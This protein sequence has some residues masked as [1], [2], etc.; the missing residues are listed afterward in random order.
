MDEQVMKREIMEAVAEALVRNM[1]DTLLASLERR[2]L[3]I[4]PAGPPAQPITSE[5]DAHAAAAAAN[6]NE[7][8][9]DGH[10][11]TEGA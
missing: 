5:A 4:C 7:G 1:A 6:Q 2:G 3:T 11:A 10:A 8:K 9:V